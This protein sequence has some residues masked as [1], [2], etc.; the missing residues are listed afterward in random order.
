MP[1][2]KQDFMEGG[3]PSMNRAVAAAAT[4]SSMYESFQDLTSIQVSHFVEWFSG[5]SWPSNWTLYDSVGTGS[6]TMADE[7]D[8]GAFLSCSTSASSYRVAWFNNKRHYDHSGSVIIFTL[9]RTSGEA[10]AHAGLCNT[11]DAET[12][13]AYMQDNSASTYKFLRTG[14][15]STNSQT[16]SS[17]AVDTSWHNF[18]IE[19]GSSNVKLYIDGVLEVTKTTNRPTA[20]MQPRMLIGSTGTATTKT[21]QIR[22]LEAYNTSVSI[23]SSLYERLSA[24]TQ[25]A[26][27]RVVENF[28]GSGLQTN[29][30]TTRNVAGSPVFGMTDEID[31]GYQIT[32]ATTANEF[33]SLD[34]NSKRQYDEDNAVCVGVIKTDATNN[35][36]VFVGFGGVVANPNTENAVGGIETN[37]STSK[38]ITQSADATT[39]SSTASSVDLD[40]NPH[41]NKIDLSASDCKY[42]LDGVL[43]VTKSTNLPTDKVQPVF[44]CQRQGADMIGQIRYLEAYNKLGTEADYSSVYELFEP[45]T[46]VRKS[47][48][49]EW[50]DGD[51]RDTTRWTSTNFGGTN[52]FQMSDG[53]D[54]GFEIVTQASTNARGQIDFNGIRHYDESA[55]ELIFVMQRVSTNCAVHCGFLQSNELFNS[56]DDSASWQESTANTYKNVYSTDGSTAS[57]TNSS[58]AIDTNFHVYKL[59]MN[60]PTNIQGYIDGVLEVTKTTNLPNVG[61]NEPAFLVKTLSASSGTGRIRFLEGYNT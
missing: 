33:G 29:R 58:V 48:F 13:D 23:N 19:I 30:W 2:F 3:F 35:R 36:L 5:S 22:Y 10:Y 42:Y 1:I 25:V 28:S 41:V 46:S 54:Q 34:F 47:H 59:V 51:D 24:L 7:V 60:C 56:G 4:L 50:F 6:A 12:D 39:K 18:K 26:G 40:T 55:S 32:C 37:S 44:W 45:L 17:I 20:K 16:D 11:R 14:D 57:T 52:T 21:M 9:K 15:A 49:W 38:F 43:E 31:G 53:I 27:Q 8:G 61:R